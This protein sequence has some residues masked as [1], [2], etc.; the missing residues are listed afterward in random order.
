MQKQRADEFASEQERKRKEKARI[1]GDLLKQQQRKMQ[2]DMDYAQVLAEL[3]EHEAEEKERCKEEAQRQK[4][5]VICLKVCE[6]C[7]DL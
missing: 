7:V 5:L 2:Q 3:H 4:R 6:M 1:L